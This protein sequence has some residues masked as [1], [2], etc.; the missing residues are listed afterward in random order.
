L[1]YAFFFSYFP[2][3]NLSHFSWS[4]GRYSHFYFPCVPSLW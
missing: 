1:N 2:P 4:R 3:Q